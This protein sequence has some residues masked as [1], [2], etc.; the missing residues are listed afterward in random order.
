MR[1]KKY[2]APSIEI[3][4]HRVRNELGPDALIL[5]TQKIK[6]RP[7]FSIFKKEIFEVTAALDNNREK[8]AASVAKPK[9][10]KVQ[11]N[12]INV[13]E[14]RFVQLQKQLADVGSMVMNIKTQL[15]TG[16]VKLPDAFTKTY[17]DMIFENQFDNEIAE[18]LLFEI[19]QNLGDKSASVS[20]KEIRTELQ[21]L[22]AGKINVTGAV[23]LDADKR[24]VVVLVGPTG[25]GKTTTMAKLA[26]HFSLVE[27]RKVA[28]I[29][30]DTYRIAAVD[31]LKT[32]AEIINIPL[33][34]IVNPQECRSTL[35]VHSDKDIVLID[36]A[37][38]SPYN[39][40]QVEELKKLIKASSPCETHLV[41]SSATALPDTLKA[42]EAFGR[43]NINS[44]LFTKIDEA[45]G[46]GRLVSIL[47]KTGLPMSYVTN[48]Q[49]VPQDITV[50]DAGQISSLVASSLEKESIAS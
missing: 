1:I 39:K 48:G 37:G 32:Y 44:L 50:Y 20:D 26:A 21:N 43:D 30:A 31:Q 29:T 25:V 15:N 27:N 34:V 3:A 4:L 11:G 6:K 10:G 35:A 13:F 16:N 19:S 24:K 47:I 36:T 23:K 49:N 28:L 12:P 17:Q 14:S 2:E 22:I 33:D 18:K 42:I 8:P 7:R 9:N 5:Q 38:R 41:L 45:S 40:E 46:L